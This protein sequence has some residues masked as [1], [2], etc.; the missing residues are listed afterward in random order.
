M[1][2]SSSSSVAS[3]ASDGEQTAVRALI[4]VTFSVHERD[5]LSILGRPDRKKRLFF[6]PSP[7]TNLSKGLSMRDLGRT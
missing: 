1:W 5:T 6:T 2:T 7:H 4:A 3:A